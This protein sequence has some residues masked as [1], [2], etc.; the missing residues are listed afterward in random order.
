MEI[1][2]RMRRLE[3]EVMDEDK[4]VHPCLVRFL[5]LLAWASHRPR[6]SCLHKRTSTLCAKRSEKDC[7]AAANIKPEAQEIRPMLC[8]PKTRMKS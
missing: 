4:E 5:G 2:D 6:L 1:S 7:E 3:I 8:T